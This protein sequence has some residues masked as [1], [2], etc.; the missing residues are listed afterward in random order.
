MNRLACVGIGVAAAVV[1][2]L[3]W[4]VTGVRL[5][6][7]NLWAVQTLPE[8][9]P[10]AL[11]PFSQYAVVQIFSLLV[12]GYGAAGI[13][14][15]ALRTRLPRRAV[16]TVGAGA[17]SVHLVA[18]VQATRAV[19]SGLAERTASMVYLVALLAVVAAAVLTG[20]LVLRLITAPPRA[21]AVIGLS[22]VALV[23][24]PWLADLLMPLGTAPGEVRSSVLNL[25]VRW[26]P[27]VLVGAAIAWGGQRTP[28]PNGRLARPHSRCGIR[29]RP[30]RSRQ[31]M[32]HR[33]DEH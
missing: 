30:R 26:V 5:P 27:A 31:R 8:D 32:A 23:A 3:P 11:L 25:V 29:R 13:V 6:L 4:L 14:V 10:I 18:T 2:L 33:T 1:A 28:G 17:L 9:M 19:A 21:G 16:L 15:R 12:V 22:L 24:G 20:L 7:Q